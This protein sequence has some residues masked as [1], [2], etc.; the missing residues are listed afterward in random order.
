MLWDTPLCPHAILHLKHQLLHSKR[1]E[2][3]CWAGIH[4]AGI[5][6]VP[7]TVGLAGV[8]LEGGTTKCPQ[9][10]QLCELVT[11]GTPE[12]AARSCGNP[13]ISMDVSVTE[14]QPEPGQWGLSCY[15]TAQTILARFR[16]PSLHK[17]ACFG[18]LVGVFCCVWGLVF[19]LRMPA[20]YTY[21]QKD[22]LVRN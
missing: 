13:G 5:H 8:P 15:I 4:G 6:G 16:P 10:R 18:V 20:F 2:S 9:S 22:F 14:L 7:W 21:L 12:Q 11:H 3:S 17:L 1:Q 19:F